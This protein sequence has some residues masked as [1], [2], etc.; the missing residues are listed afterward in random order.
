[1]KDYDGLP[2]DNNT[3]APTRTLK[4]ATTSRQNKTVSNIIYTVTEDTYIP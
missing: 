3:H 2:T 4:A 1:M